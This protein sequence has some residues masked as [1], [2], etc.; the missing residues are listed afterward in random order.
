MTVVKTSTFDIFFGWLWS[1][2]GLLELLATDGVGLTYYN[3][4]VID[5]LGA[6]NKCHVINRSFDRDQ[7]EIGPTPTSNFRVSI[8]KPLFQNVWCSNV[9]T[10]RITSY[11]FIS[12]LCV[13]GL[14]N[15]IC[16]SS[17]LRSAM[18]LQVK[19][20][21]ISKSITNICATNMQKIIERTHSRR[22]E[23]YKPDKTC[24]SGSISTALFR[25][26]Q[27]NLIGRKNIRQ[28][29]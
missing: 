24:G 15:S 28:L 18:M 1:V 2:L 13:G 19:K 14:H 26:C 4:C 11:L 3:N 16:I 21:T 6:Q 9:T 27:V 29:L 7:Q 8:R 23:Q 5:L 22:L 17:S 25:S 10:R 12:V 20:Q